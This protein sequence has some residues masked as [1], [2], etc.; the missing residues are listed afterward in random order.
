MFIALTSLI[1]LFCF[2]L[3]RKQ[4]IFIVVTSLMR[5]HFEKHAFLHHILVFS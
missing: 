1:F 3:Y 5:S 2:L 4:Q